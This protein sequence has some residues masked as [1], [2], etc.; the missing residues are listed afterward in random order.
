M[1]S[2]YLLTHPVTLERILLAI[3]YLH[4][5]FKRLPIAP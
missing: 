5:A 3:L 1:L 4:I 2:S